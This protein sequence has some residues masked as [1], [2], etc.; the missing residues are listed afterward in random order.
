MA[1]DIEVRVAGRSFGYRGETYGH[2][3]E[4]TVDEDTAENHPN[5]LERVDSDDSDSD[6]TEAASGTDDD[7]EPESES[8][9]RDELEEMDRSG[10]QQLASDADTDEID[11]RSSSEDIIDT[12]VEG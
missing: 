7:T 5:T 2:D 8:Y 9:T 12:L 1:D 10:L 6:E 3:E 11:G 4:L